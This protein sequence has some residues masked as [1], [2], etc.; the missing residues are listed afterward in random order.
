MKSGITGL[1][2]INGL[3]GKTSLSDRVELDNHYIENWSFWLDFK[4]VA[5][6]LPAVVTAFSVV[7]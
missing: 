3:R 6:T 4:I 2:Q 1:A 5:L 7:E